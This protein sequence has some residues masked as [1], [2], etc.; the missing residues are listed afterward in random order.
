[1]TRRIARLFAAAAVALSL[2]LVLDSVYALARP[3]EA[4]TANFASASR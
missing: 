3:A 2:L 4:I 1:M